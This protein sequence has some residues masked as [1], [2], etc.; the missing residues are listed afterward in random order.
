MYLNEISDDDLFQ[1]IYFEKLDLDKWKGEKIDQ[2]EMITQRAD[3]LF[4]TGK[5]DKS[6]LLRLKN[7][8]KTILLN[9]KKLLEELGESYNFKCR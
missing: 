5:Y 9:T 8:I 2:K 3:I 6:T 4:D 1:I 7:K